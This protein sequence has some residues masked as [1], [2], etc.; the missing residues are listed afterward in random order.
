MGNNQEIRQR[1][2]T[3][4][5]I[6]L[7]LNWIGAVILIIVGIV[8]VIS[9]YTRG[10]GIGVIIGSVVIGVIGHF[11]I[12]VALAIPFILLNNGDI[13][14]SIKGIVKGDSSLDSNDEHIDKQKESTVKNV[15]KA[16]TSI[17]KE[18]TL[19]SEIAFTLSEA[20]EVSLIEKGGNIPF[21]ND[22]WIKIMCKNGITGWCYLSSLEK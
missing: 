11:L 2:E 20:E 22:Q 9:G 15:V 3:Y 5:S 1:M 14:K 13:L 18:Q 19:N 10:I 8:L 12:N 4:R 17:Y 16:K 6:L 21:V 7:V